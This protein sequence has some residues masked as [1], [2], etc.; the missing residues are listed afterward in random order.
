[1]RIS[2]TEEYCISIPKKPHFVVATPSNVGIIYSEP[3]S[4]TTGKTGSKTCSTT[5]CPRRSLL[6]P[7]FPSLLYS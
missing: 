6:D 2:G 7:R 5:T 1:M 4:V 3:R